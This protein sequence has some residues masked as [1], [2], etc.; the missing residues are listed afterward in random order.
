LPASWD[1]TSDSIAARL[2]QVLE[3]A[4]H[5]LLNSALPPQPKSLQKKD[6]TRF[7]DAFFPIAAGCLRVVR[8]VNLRDPNFAETIALRESS[9]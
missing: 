8:L 3:A 9:R 4:D 2:A 7:V 1:D 6:E 5:V